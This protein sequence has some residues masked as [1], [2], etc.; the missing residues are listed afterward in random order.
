MAVTN[1]F[2]NA[3][4]SGGVSSITHVALLDDGGVELDRQA[5]TWGSPSD[6][7]VHPT[8]DIDFDVAAGKTVGGWA[9]FDAATGGTSYGGSDLTNES[10]T[11]AGTYTLTASGTGYDLN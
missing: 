2:L 7:A 8:A 9:G 1:A 11:N 5:V 10:F 6:G 4:A 3:A